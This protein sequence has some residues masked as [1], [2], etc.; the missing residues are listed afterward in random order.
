MFTTW[1]PQCTPPTL[2]TRDY[3]DIRAFLEQHGDLVLKPLEGM[4]GA[5]VFR[6][7][8]SDPNLS[9]IMENLTHHQSR[10]IMAQRFIEE[11][12]EGDKRVLMINGEAVPYAL[13]R[14][15]A[16]GELRGNLAAGATGVGKRLSE[17]DRWICREVGP[18]LRR[19]GIVFSGLDIIGDYLTEINVTSPTG[20]RE[21]DRIFDENIAGR[22]LDAVE[23][24]IQTR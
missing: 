13:A 1:F 24:L 17:R 22:L 18:V 8:A 5:S 21:L 15:P 16:P 11:I 9:V 7:G 12:S 20:I 4:G 19:K 23:K 3:R 2:V 6:V 10:Y 14:I